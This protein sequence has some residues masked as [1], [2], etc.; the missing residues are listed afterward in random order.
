MCGGENFVPGGE[1]GSS[2]INFG[3]PMDLFG[4][5]RRADAKRA[6]SEAKAA[7]AAR[8]ARISGNVKDINSTFDARE[9]QY[10]QLGEALRGRLNEGVQLQQQNAARKSKFAL[11]RGG[12]I[13]GSQQRDQS[14]VLNR[15]GRDASLAAERE[16]QKGV[17]GL[18][19]ADEDARA[20]M[21]GLAQSGNDIGNAAAQTASALKANLGAAQGAGNVANLGDLFGNTAA[22]YRAQEDAAARRRGFTEAQTYSKPFS[23]GP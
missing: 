7:E 21:I 1:A 6:S 10:A 16:V 8:Q 13:G 18:R 20:R 11:A 19:T 17:A 2:G 4:G 5:Q 12:L 3:D 14:A 22:T 23:R 9:P 15:E